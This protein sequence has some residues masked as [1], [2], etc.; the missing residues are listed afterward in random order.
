M[1]NVRIVL[2]QG[3]IDGVNRVFATGEPYVPGSTAYILNGRIHNRSLPRGPDNDYGYIEL[4]PAAG[5]IEVDNPPL[6]DDVVQIF[7]WS[8]KVV[9]APAV[10]RIVGVVAA[11]QHVQG[12]IREQVPARLVGVVRGRAIAGVLREPSADRLV[13]QVTTQRIIG[14]IKE[15]CP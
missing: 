5:T 6:T 4:D 8:R 9:P 2:A 11:P 1:A 3:A 13:G 14:V 15:K 12:V 7:F 10:D